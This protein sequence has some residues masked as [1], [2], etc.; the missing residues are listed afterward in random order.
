MKSLLLSIV[1]GVFAFTATVAAQS[2][3][4][5]WDA[6][7]QTPGGV[8]TVKMVFQ[9]NGDTLTGTVKRPA[10]DV[11]LVGTIKGNAVK[12]SYTI[13]YEGN[14]LVLTVTATVAGDSMKGMVD[15]GGMA[16]DEFAATRVSGAPRSP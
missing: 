14:P 5:E 3:A 2:I 1:G 15:F 7:L 11:P 8:R 9:V 12:F 4:G 16:E 13:N 6:T 10:G